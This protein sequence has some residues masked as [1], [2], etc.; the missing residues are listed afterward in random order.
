M[1]PAQVVALDIATGAVAAATIAGW[2]CSDPG[3][4]QFDGSYAFERLRVGAS[5][6]YQVYAEPLDGPVTLGD[7]IYSPTGVCRNSATDPGW[8]T[9]FACALPTSAAPF[10]ARVRPGP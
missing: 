6:G 8:P 3:P 5:Q 9:Q 10:A 4:A 2:T 1:F 7:V